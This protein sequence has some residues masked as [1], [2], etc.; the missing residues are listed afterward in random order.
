MIRLKQDLTE[1]ERKWVVRLLWEMIVL[2]EKGQTPYWTTEQ[3]RHI[4]FELQPV[5]SEYEDA[6]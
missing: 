6:A 2:V 1:G 4:A 3:L 5:G